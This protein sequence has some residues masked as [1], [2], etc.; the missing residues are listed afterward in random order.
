MH[1]WLV[2]FVEA[3][4][5]QRLLGHTCEGV[6]LALFS[7]F[8]AGRTVGLFVASVE[9][10]KVWRGGRGRHSSRYASLVNAGALHCAQNYNEK[11]TTA[12]T[13]VTDTAAPSPAF[14]TQ[15]R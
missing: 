5:W 3:C 7:G 14:L 2:G 12:R 1:R 11:P 13:T 8:V 10:T 6:P 4:L 15:M 9:M